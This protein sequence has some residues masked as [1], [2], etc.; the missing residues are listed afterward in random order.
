VVLA[1][2]PHLSAFAIDSTSAYWTNLDRAGM[3]CTQCNGTVMKIP[4][5]GGTPVALAAGQASPA[6]IAVG[7]SDLVWANAGDGTGNGTMM[8]M[9]LR[10][11]AAVALVSNPSPLIPTTLAVDGTSIYWTNQGNAGTPC[12]RPCGVMRMPLGGGNPVNLAPGMFGAV[13]AT[14]IYWAGDNG[15]MRMP[16]GG[17]NSMILLSGAPA[18]PVPFAVDATTLYWAGIH[19]LWSAPL[20]G[21]QFYGNSARISPL[22]PELDRTSHLIPTSIAVDATSV[23]WTDAKQ[24]VIGLNPVI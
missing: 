1:S 23:Y 4:L 2:G 18:D 7:A 10:G 17:G 16:L 6:G 9:P 12:T 24:L 5:D 15:L 22:G 14:S 11:G 20:T 21:G 8:R 3:S 19:T 13:D